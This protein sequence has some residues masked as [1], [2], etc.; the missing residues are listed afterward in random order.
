[1]VSAL[2]ALATLAVVSVVVTFAAQLALH[3]AALRAARGRERCPDDDEPRSLLALLPAVVRETVLSLLVLLLWPLG[4]RD[5]AATDRRAVVLV[6]GFATSPVS[7]W[8]LAR[9]LERD[10]WAVSV[11]RLGPWWSDL[12]AAADRIAQHIDRLRLRADVTGLV[13]VAHG[14]GGL[15][16]RLLLGREGRHARVRLLV[17]LG[18]PH[19]GTDALPAVRVGPW[20]R[21]VRPGSD[22]LRALDATA[23][24]PLLDTIAI[25]ASEDA[26]VIPPE[27]GRWSR[28]CNISVSGSGHLDLLVSSRVYDVLAENLAAVPLAALQG[29]GR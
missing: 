3:R 4:R 19:G 17:T 28:A 20:R 24:P 29:H 21:A 7:L 12:E 10:G 14:L 6:H 5:A 15:A 16:M 8:L 27:H 23:L 1:M 25:A 22:V 11:P 26:L 9:R 2:G 13:V 18:T